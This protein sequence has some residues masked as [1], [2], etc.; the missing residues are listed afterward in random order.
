MGCKET[1]KGL[2]IFEVVEDSAAEE[3]GLRGGDILAKVNGEPIDT[4]EEL[5]IAIATNEPG[6]TVTVECRRGDKE[7]SFRIKL[8]RYP[9]NEEEEDGG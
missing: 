2:E 8:G 3:A 6:E 1:E 7:M 9:G 5:T 4:R